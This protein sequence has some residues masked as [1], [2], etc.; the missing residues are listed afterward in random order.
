MSV[1]VFSNNLRFQVVLCVL[2]VANAVNVVTGDSEIRFPG[3]DVSITEG[4]FNLG[5]PVAMLFLWTRFGHLFNSLIQNRVVLWKLL[6]ALKDPKHSD[7]LTLRSLLHD[8]ALLDAYFLHFHPRLHMLWAPG[9]WASATIL[10][11]YAGVFGAIHTAILGTA[12][13]G[14][15]SAVAGN[16]HPLL[17]CCLINSRR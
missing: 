11:S 10:G 17:V 5:L 8:H 14:G 3:L 6:D 16:V 2:A 9:R 15:R 12:Y 4:I 7:V 1:K 13:L